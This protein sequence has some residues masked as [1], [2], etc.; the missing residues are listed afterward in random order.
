MRNFSFLLGTKNAKFFAAMRSSEVS[1]AVTRTSKF[2]LAA[3]FLLLISAGANAQLQRNDSER[4]LLEARNRKR[5]A[6]SLPGLQWDGPLFEAA[7]P[8]APRLPNLN[9]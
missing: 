6:Q 4:Q 1:L 9:L 7:L 3:I 5:A 2:L 8:H